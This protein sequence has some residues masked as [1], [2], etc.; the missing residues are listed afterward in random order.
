MPWCDTTAEC[1]RKKFI[2][3]LRDRRY[4][5]SELC[6]KYGISGKTGYTWIERFRLEGVQGLDDRS[7]APLVVHNQAVV[8]QAWC[9]P[10]ADR[11]RQA[12]AERST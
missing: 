9:A 1:E 8:D 6:A 12:A 10:G 2:D 7:R 3:D 4:S 5:M 11:A